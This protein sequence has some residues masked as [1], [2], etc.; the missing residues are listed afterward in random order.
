[1]NVERSN[2]FS[3]SKTHLL[4]RMANIG[5]GHAAQHLPNPNTLKNIQLWSIH[6]IISELFAKKSATCVAALPIRWYRN[7]SSFQK[8][9]MTK[10]PYCLSVANF[11]L[12]GISWHLG[13]LVQLMYT[14]KI[15]FVLYSVCF[16]KLSNVSGDR[17]FVL[18]WESHGRLYVGVVTVNWFI[19]AF[20]CPLQYVHCAI[21][22][23]KCYDKPRLIF[24]SSWLL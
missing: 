20:S 22:A 6:A 16:V 4:F 17:H 9:T 1:M 15:T 18:L 7:S 24:D 21:V 11:T 13:I 23:C 3:H 5:R 14:R 19:E 10:S 8:C 12:H 2:F